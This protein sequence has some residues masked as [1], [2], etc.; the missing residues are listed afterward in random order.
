MTLTYVPRDVCSRSVTSVDMPGH[1]QLLASKAY[2]NSSSHT[3]CS[4]KNKTI[5]ISRVLVDGAQN[6]NY[7]QVCL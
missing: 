6:L 1:M 4:A 2:L 7:Q 5:F 3:T